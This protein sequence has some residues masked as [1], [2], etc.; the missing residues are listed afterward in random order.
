MGNA[1][2]DQNEI[3]IVIR[4]DIVTDIPVATTV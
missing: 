1:W 3:A 2:A 4:L